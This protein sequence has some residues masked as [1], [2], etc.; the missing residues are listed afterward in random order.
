M[1][2]THPETLPLFDAISKEISR[3]QQLA[4]IVSSLNTQNN[5]TNEEYNKIT[6]E[7]AA[8]RE[9]EEQQ[10]NDIEE[11]ERKLQLMYSEEQEVNR[12]VASAEAG[13]AE[14]RQLLRFK[15]ELREEEATT[16]KIALEKEN[17]M[18][19][20]AK[21]RKVMHDKVLERNTR[22]R[23]AFMEHEVEIRWLIISVFSLQ[24]I[25]IQGPG[26]AEPQQAIPNS[27]SRTITARTAR[28]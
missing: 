21:Q 26:C 15:E 17:E 24:L 25:I 6:K 14:Q 2:K 7:I 22:Q 11:L 13:L 10:R 16:S 5:L 1:S 12:A 19:F 28:G 3:G 4:S 18:V 20:A 9:Q 27:N 23:V 8:L